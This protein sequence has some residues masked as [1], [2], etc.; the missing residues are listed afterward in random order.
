MK[1]IFLGLILFSVKDEIKEINAG[2]SFYPCINWKTRPWI[3]GSHHISE[4]HTNRC[5][6]A[7]EIAGTREKIL[8]NAYDR[9]FRIFP[10]PQFQSFFPVYSN[11]TVRHICVKSCPTKVSSLHLHFLS[12]IFRRQFSNQEGEIFSSSRFQERQMENFFV[13]RSGDIPPFCHCA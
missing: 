5:P 2:H 1:K 10:F 11:V 3:L 4:N 7:K 8:E 13:Q 6:A 9:D 12:A